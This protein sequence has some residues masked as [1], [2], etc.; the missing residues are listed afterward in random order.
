MGKT[1]IRY[2]GRGI[3]GWIEENVFYSHVNG[4]NFFRNFGGWGKSIP[5]LARLNDMGVEKVV[6]IIDRDTPISTPLMNFFEHGE[7]YFDTP[8]DPQLILAQSFWA[9]EDRVPE[10]KQV[11]LF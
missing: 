5:I 7:K 6:L 2:P 9:R 3:V 11:K 8:D 4:A 1:Y 10:E